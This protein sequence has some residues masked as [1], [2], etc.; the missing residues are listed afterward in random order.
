MRRIQNVYNYDD[1]KEREML[2][3]GIPNPNPYYKPPI[4]TQAE[5][6]EMVIVVDQQILDIVDEIF[7]DSLLDRKSQVYND[8]DN[9]PEK[10]KGGAV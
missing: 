3:Q 8:L 7:P 5:N 10:T 9:T 1:P 2:R 6:G 4:Q